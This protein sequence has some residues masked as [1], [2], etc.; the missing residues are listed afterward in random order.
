M[1]R[2][3]HILVLAALLSLIASDAF[4]RN[5]RQ[6]QIPNNIYGCE[7]C[8]T[9]AGGLNDFGF[10]SF[11]H[12]AGGTVN[13]ATL[14]QMDSDNDGYS[15]GLE[16]A[17]PGGTGANNGG[18]ITHPGDRNDGLCG[19]GSMEGAE[20]CESGNLGGATCASMG[21]VSGNLACGS[22]CRFDTSN[23]T[24]CGNGTMEGGEEC[25]GADLGGNTCESLGRGTGT[26]S[27]GGCAYNYTGCMDDSDAT[28]MTCGDGVRQDPESCDGSDRGGQT[29][30][31]LGYTGGVLGCEVRCGFDTSGCIGPPPTGSDDSPTTTPTV[32]GNGTNSPGPAGLDDNDQ[33]IEL[34]GRACSTTTG[35][36][37]PVNGF[38]LMFAL[39]LIWRRRQRA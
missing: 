39:A 31:T 19:N 37:S 7:V 17:D 18:T 33:K 3:T 25:D 26:L 4:A 22:T 6:N 1:G 24:S 30:A 8:H 5:G 16:L 13:W 36:P 20:E 10:G 34:D 11:Q 35:Q 9:V 2:H 28:P 21:L 29:C 23:C 12:T 15:N 27:C 32:T 14:S 38:V